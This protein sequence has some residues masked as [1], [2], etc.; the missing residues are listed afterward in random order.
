M[1][2]PPQN[3]I[4]YGFYLPIHLRMS[5]H[6]AI[7]MFKDRKTMQVPGSVGGEHGCQNVLSDGER[8]V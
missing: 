7:Y 8:T 6:V 4:P 5:R 1:Q 3:I 2:V